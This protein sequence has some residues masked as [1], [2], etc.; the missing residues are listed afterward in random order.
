MPTVNQQELEIT[1]TISTKF[2]R[3]RGVKYVAMEP[4]QLKFR[5]SFLIFMRQCQIN[6]LPDPLKWTFELKTERHNTRLNNLLKLQDINWNS[7][8]NQF[9]SEA[10]C[11]W[12]TLE[13]GNEDSCVCVFVCVCVCV[14]VCVC[15]C[16]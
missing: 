12:V 14:F 4:E 16:L 1:K 13:R 2:E 8:E 10:T 6:S 15:V 5:R 7:A 11:Y 9:H 3:Q